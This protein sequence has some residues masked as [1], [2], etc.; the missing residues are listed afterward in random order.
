MTPNEE[1]VR[2]AL[3]AAGFHD[4]DR[5]GWLRRGF[6][7]PRLDFGVEIVGSRLFDGQTSRTTIL[8]DKDSPEVAFASIEDMIA[9]RMGQFNATTP[10]D[11]RLLE[12]AKMLF[13]LAG[14]MDHAYLDIRIRA[15][16]PDYDL[17]YLETC[18]DDS[19]PS[20]YAD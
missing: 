16:A 5:A 14:E 2:A 10:G 17:N 13:L 11:A 12:Q 8:P 7:H 3:L 18:V 9:D 15:E 4:E 20:Q 19:P 1:Q 6:Y